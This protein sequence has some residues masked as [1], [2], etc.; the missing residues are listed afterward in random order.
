MDI[1]L[2]A[3]DERWGRL[4]ADGVYHWPSVDLSNKL[5]QREAVEPHYVGGLH[6]DGSRWFVIPSFEWTENGWRVAEPE[7]VMLEVVAELTAPEVIEIPVAV[8]YKDPQPTV[9]V[10]DPDHLIIEGEPAATNI[11]IIEGKVA[12]DKLPEPV[13]TKKTRK[14]SKG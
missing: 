7:S 13:D 14:S 3:N 8:V 4:D 11:E 12:D 1:I 9:E 2:N 10:A 5:Y 6:E